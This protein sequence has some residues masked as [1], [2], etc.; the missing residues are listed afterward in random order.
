MLTKENK[1]RGILTFYSPKHEYTSLTK[2]IGLFLCVKLS[3]ERERERER[4]RVREKKE[5]D[6]L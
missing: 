6:C 3:R 5:K 4:E 2:Q 1:K